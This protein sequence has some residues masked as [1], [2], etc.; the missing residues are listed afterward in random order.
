M[1]GFG[2]LIN[3]GGIVL[4]GLSGHFF[5]RLLKERHQSSLT[6]AC[7]ISVFFIGMP[8]ADGDDV[9]Q[10][11]LQRLAVLLIHSHEKCR[12]HNDHHQHGGRAG[13][14]GL[15]QQE[16]QR[17]A[18]KRAAAKANELPFREIEQHL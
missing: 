6:A 1:L 10:Y 7:G 8:K 9:F 15:P 5:G 11:D 16:E 4:A 2:T 13:A 17:Y 18:R 14:E 12:E 3:T